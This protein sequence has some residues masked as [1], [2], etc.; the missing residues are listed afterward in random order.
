MSVKVSRKR[1]EMGARV[2]ARGS[3][4][5]GERLWRAFE[6]E[7][8]MVGQAVKPLPRQV[9]RLAIGIGGNRDRTGL[10]QRR[11]A[12]IG[13]IVLRARR[14]IIRI[15]IGIFMMGV[16]ALSI[17]VCVQKTHDGML[18]IAGSGD[19][20]EI[21]EEVDVGHSEKKRYDANAQKGV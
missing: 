2:T 12:Q 21:V 20:L 16:D 15:C 5:L 13:M 9:R 19:V 18:M 1:S 6:R 8:Q 4:S 11:A 10:G 3:Q 7:C 14:V 17:V